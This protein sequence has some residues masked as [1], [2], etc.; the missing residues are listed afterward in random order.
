MYVSPGLFHR[1]VV[2]LNHDDPL[3]GHFKFAHT[4]ILIQRKYYWPGINK[5]NK[6]YVNTCDICHR[7][8]PV[9]HKPYGKLSALPPPRAPFTDLIMDFITDMPPS[10]FYSI[11]YDSIFIVMY[12]Y[13]K[14]VRY[15]PAQ[16]DWTAKRLAKA[17]IEDIWREKGLPDSIVS[18]RGSLFTSKFWSAICFHLKI[19]Q[20]LSS[21]F[22]PQTDGQTERQNQTLEQYLRGYANYQQDDWVTW[23][24]I[25]E[26][27]YN[28]SVYSATGESPFFL[29]YRLYP[30]M[31]D[32]LKLL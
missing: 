14:L 2:R 27:A 15:T 3:A 30:I 24:A 32:S 8:K 11:V 7:I 26:F 1:E 5:D 12:R 23:L 10:E 18:D 13:T 31:P 28:N 21:V 4:L 20:R 17:F 9:R 22:H 25:A 16:M 29:A 19:K 6:S